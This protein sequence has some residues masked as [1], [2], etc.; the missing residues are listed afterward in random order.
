MSG[1]PY[2]NLVFEGGG[3]RGL[4]YVG[5]LQAVEEAGLRPQVK[6][7]AGTSAGAITAALIAMGYSADELRQELLGMRLGMFE[8]G[9]L[10]GPIRVITHYGFFR[11]DTFLHWMRDR[12][13]QKVGNRT[14]TFKQVHAKTGID[15]RVVVCNL[16]TRS[17][18]V[19]SHTAS[20]DMELALGVRMSMSIPLF[21]AAVRDQ[22]QV[23]VDGGTVWNY[24]LT[25]F[26]ADHPE[27]TTLGFHLGA[28]PGH[29]A[30]AKIDDVID[31]DRALYESLINVQS[32]LIELDPDAAKR[33]VF[34]DHLG[35]NP[36][37]FAIDTAT[38][39]AL[40]KSGYDAAKAFLRDAA[41]G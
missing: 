15:L 4:C 41:A 17:P 1:F 14:A 22:G 31:Y 19:L 10:T 13:Q 27:H 21:F 30:P 9:L 40:V 2:T 12:V 23:F 36:V 24:P 39:Q 18:Q 33:S 11:G 38:K 8:D 6:A 29:P 32:F 5:A 7:V 25:V 26:D 37:D 3:V 34:I 35:V 20:P 16:S 28:R